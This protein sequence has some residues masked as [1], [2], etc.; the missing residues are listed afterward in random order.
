MQQ[1]KALALLKSGKN[2]FITGSAGSGKTYVLNQYINYLKDRKVPVAVTA[3]TGIAA[4][5]MNGQT[6]HSWSGIGVKDAI[7]NTDLKKMKDKKYLSRGLNNTKVL[8]IDE[9]SMLH[10]NQL[11]MVN[12]VLQF[13]KENDQPFGGIQLVLSGDFFQLPPVTKNNESN[14]ERFAFM[15]QS[16]LD[17]GLSICYLTGQYRQSDNSLNRILNEIRSNQV[18]PA[19]LDLLRNA[20]DQQIS[21]VPTKLYTHNHDVDVINRAELDALKGDP[22]YFTATTK[23]NAKML[24]TLKKSVLADLVLSLKKGARVMFVR[25]NYDK[26]YVNGTLGEVVGFDSEEDYPRVRLMDGRVITASP[27]KWSIEDEKGNTLASFEQVPLRLAW[28]ITV[29]KSQG[30]TLDAA[31]IDLS[32]TFE[33]GQGYVALSRLKDIS[34]LKLLGI[35]ETALKVDEWALRADIRFQELSMEADEKQSEDELAIG[36]D[37]FVLQ[38]GGII[39]QKEIKKKRQKKPDKSSLVDTY[40][41]TRELLLKG[42]NWDEMAEERGFARGTIAS[43]LEKIKERHPETDFTYLKPSEVLLQQVTRACEEIRKENK[44]ELIRPNGQ[45]SLKAVFEQLKGA[46]SYDEIRTAMLFVA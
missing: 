30:M 3:S 9:I 43:H 4:T 32:R 1:Q 36:F 12:K 11:D 22:Q 41:R 28:A 34:G 46:L 2:V 19:S 39:G 38:S 31:E 21:I 10:K 17:A 29:H 35:N 13:F 33:K 24:E 44:S 15:S 7:T 45:P 8:L 26:G 5:H 14:R 27:E 23:G 20:G 40:E 25:N 18:T 16:W 37:N 6:I 42:M